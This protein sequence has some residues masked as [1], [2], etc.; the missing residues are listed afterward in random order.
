MKR[1]IF[2][3]TIGIIVEFWLT[4]LLQPVQGQENTVHSI[5]GKLF[6]SPTVTPTPSP[7]PTPTPTPTPAF[8]QPVYVQISSLGINAPVENISVDS[9]G[10]MGVPAN[11]YNVGWYMLGARIG[12]Q[13]N[14]ILTGHYDTTTGTPAIFNRLSQIPIGADVVIT[15]EIGR[16][17]RYMVEHS[18]SRPLGSWSMEEVFGPSSERRLNLI[19]CSGWWNMRARTYSHRHIVFARLVE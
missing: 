17:M 11:P 7:T 1:L 19:T 2:F 5:V 18:E 9:M 14:A 8:G 4:S 10:R 3:L 13:G 12:W 6:P 15:D 16:T